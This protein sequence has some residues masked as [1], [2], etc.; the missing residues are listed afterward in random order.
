M[1]VGTALHR[2]LVEATLFPLTGAI[3][4]WMTVHATRIRQ[5]FSELD[6]HRR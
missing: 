6:E 2:R 3:A 4:G 5:H 1:T